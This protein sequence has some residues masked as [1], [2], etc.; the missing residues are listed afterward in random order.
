VGGQLI[1]PSLSLSELVHSSHILLPRMTGRRAC[2]R[3]KYS[4]F[5]VLYLLRLNLHFLLSFALNIAR[6]CT[7][8]PP[9]KIRG[10]FHINSDIIILPGRVSY[11]IRGSTAPTGQGHP[12]TQ[13]HRP[14]C[15]ME[16]RWYLEKQRNSAIFRC[17]QCLAWFIRECV[18]NSQVQ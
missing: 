11:F 10:L 3:S 16:F 7:L 8:S 15:Y 4:S 13:G 12:S 9:E 2:T 18:A 1:L 17:P 14:E 5:S 6:T